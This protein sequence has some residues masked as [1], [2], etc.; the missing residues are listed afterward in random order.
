MRPGP[1]A[2]RPQST[3]R[4]L[5]TGLALWC[6]GIQ[7]AFLVLAILQSRAQVVSTRTFQLAAV[8]M[9]VFA[10]AVHSLLVMHFIGSMKWIQQSGP[11]AGVEDTQSCGERGSRARS[12]RCWCSRC[13]SP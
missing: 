2:M 1:Y 6:V 10:L 8:F 11:T 5:Y 7:V 3:M 13:S 4:H 12:S 9:A